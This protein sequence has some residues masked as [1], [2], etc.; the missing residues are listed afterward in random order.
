MD[1]AD[2]WTHPSLFEMDSN[3]NPRAVAGVPPDYFAADGQL[4]GNPLYDWKRHKATNYAWWLARLRAS[5]ELYDIVRVDHFRGFDEYCKIPANAANAR[6]YE[7]VPGPGIDLFES[8]KAAFPEARLVAEDLGIITDSVRELVVATGVPGMN[9]LQFGFEGATEYL[10]H[11]GIPN[12]V[13]YPGTH[14]N[15]TAWGWFNKQSPACPGFFPPLPAGSG[16]RRALGYDTGRLRIS[17]TPFCRADAGSAE[18]GKRGPDEHAR[19]G[20]RKLAMAAHPGTNGR[21]LERERRISPELAKLYD[22]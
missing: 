19:T 14:D 1:S 11:N 8:I 7:W 21:S 13:L 17:I 18:P 6:E 2:V 16:R 3:L 20:C 9:V 5:F 15:D 4:W 22:R 10:P 12:S